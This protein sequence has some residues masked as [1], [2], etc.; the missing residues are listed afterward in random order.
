[1]QPVAIFYGFCALT[2]LGLAVASGRRGLMQLGAIMMAAWIAC[3]AATLANGFDRAT[4]LIPAIDAIL[5]L[6]TVSMVIFERDRAA[7]VVFGLFI[8][9]EI[10][11]VAAFQ[12]HTQGSV[13]Y[14]ITLNLIFLAQA[15]VVGGWSASVVVARLADT[16]RMAGRVHRG[17]LQPRARAR[18]R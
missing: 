13:S 4:L 11:H 8:L 5:A 10:V 16:P 14:F 6:L 2:A 3:N 18:S 15:V 7:T 12:T 1:M 17:W 9:V